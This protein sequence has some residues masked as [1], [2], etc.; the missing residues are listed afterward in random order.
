MWIPYTRSLTALFLGTVCCIAGC[1]SANAFVDNHCASKR[2]D[3]DL[4]QLRYDNMTMDIA[5]LPSGEQRNIFQ[6]VLDNKLNRVSASV[7]LLTPLASA[8]DL[9]RTQLALVL[10]TLADDCAKLF[11]YGNAVWYYDRLL[12]DY[13]NELSPEVRQDDSNDDSVLRLLKNAPKQS[14]SVA[15]VVD[16]PIARA[17]NGV[18][19]TILDVHG[20]SG[21]WILDTG[22]DHSVVSESFAKELGLKLSKKAASTPGFNGLPNK[23]HVAILDQLNIGSAVVRNTAVLVVPDASLRVSREGRSYVIPALLGYPIYRA[24]GKI[25]FTASGHF[26]A[27]PSLESTGASSPIYMDKLSVLVMATVHNQQRSFQLDSGANTTVLYSTYYRDFPMDFSNIRSTSTFQGSAVGGTITSPVEYTEKA[28]INIGG[29]EAA[30]NHI[31]VQ[32][33]PAHD[34]SDRYEGNIGCDLLASF[35]SATFDF[36][37]SR[38]YLGPAITAER[39]PATA[40]P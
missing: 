14:I 11:E 8:H 15:G 2:I 40:I 22:A 13:S 20:V 16:L 6:G 36:I 5:C 37:H 10:A 7:K 4:K 12:R 29:R 17:P 31:P 34:A 39:L 23:I 1:T 38:F 9:S 35:E 28:E 25:R 26:L 21:D 24:L 30:L 33:S 3:D 32:L 18:Y 27:G 19:R